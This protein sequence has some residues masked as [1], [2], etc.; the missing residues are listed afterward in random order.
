MI[1]VFQ[2]ADRLFYG[3]DQPRRLH[4]DLKI[5]MPQIHGDS[6]MAGIED[7]RFLGQRHS[8]DAQLS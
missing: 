6:E 5:A 2:L 7:D 1:H 3:L 4:V 8:Q